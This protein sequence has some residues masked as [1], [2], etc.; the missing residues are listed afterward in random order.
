M[1]SD[2]EAGNGR[3]GASVLVCDV[4][5]VLLTDGLHRVMAQAASSVGRQPAAV[6][7]LYRNS[8]LRDQLFTGAVTTH[9]FWSSFKALV[10]D[11]CLLPSDPDAAVIAG[12]QPLP[13]LAAVRPG[14]DRLWMATNHRH[15]W[16]L[17]ALRAAGFETDPQRVVCSS[18][19]VAA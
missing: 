2:P 18:L 8:G 1:T 5:E 17:P 15:E 7:Q 10:G 11:G 4:G 9:E 13:G 19:D 12:C 3:P 16:V 14:L 6:L